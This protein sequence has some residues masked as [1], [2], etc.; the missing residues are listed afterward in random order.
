M[1]VVRRVWWPLVPLAGCAAHDP[2]V[3]PAPADTSV[4]VVMFQRPALLTMVT[5]VLLIAAIVLI[6]K[7]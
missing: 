5:V 4:V 6:R 7:R 1:D 2:P 3:A